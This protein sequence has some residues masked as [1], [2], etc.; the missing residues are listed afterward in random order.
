MTN[1]WK[2]VKKAQKLK[3]SRRSPANVELAY[4]TYE[5]II[6][7]ASNR[8]SSLVNKEANTGCD[9]RDI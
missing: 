3:W 2:K 7:I 5:E 6:E 9:R 1:H 8:E 4:L